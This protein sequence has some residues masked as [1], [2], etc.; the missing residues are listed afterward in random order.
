MTII[1]ISLNDKLLKEMDSLQSS[2]GFSGRSE[3]IR[4]AM[5]SL[6][7]EQKEQAKLSGIIEGVVI[8]VTTDH[9]AHN[10]AEIRHRYEHSIKTE[11]HNHLENH[12]CLYIYVIKGEGKLIQKMLNEFKTSKEVD[13]ARLV[14]S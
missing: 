13:Y 6:L 3:V 2:M 4:T 1:S 11:I 7:S 5:R 10:L 8:V 12:K 9:H 14:V